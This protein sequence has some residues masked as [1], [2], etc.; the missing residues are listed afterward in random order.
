MSPSLNSPAYARGV[1]AICYFLELSFYT[2]LGTWG[3]EAR[4]KRNNMSEAAQKIENIILEDLPGATVSAQNIRAD[5]RDFFKVRVITP[6]F[7]GKT[8]V[9]QHR[10]IYSSLK[11]AGITDFDNLSLHTAL[12]VKR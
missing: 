10:L 11:K 7:E 9:E 2:T 12:K 4:K 3:Q 8:R 5:G 6:A 1:G